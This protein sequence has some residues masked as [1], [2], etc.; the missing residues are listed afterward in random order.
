MK[1]KTD[2]IIS[3]NRIAF[4]FPMYISYTRN[5]DAG[6]QSYID[7]CNVQLLFFA[8]SSML[9]GR[10]DFLSR[11]ALEGRLLYRDLL[12]SFSLRDKL[13]IYWASGRIADGFVARK[14]ESRQRERQSMREGSLSPSY[15]IVGSPRRHCYEPI[16]NHKMTSRESY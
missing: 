6:I 9:R 11:G 16:R 2:T 12:A 15:V 14:K 8:R 4:T 10:R 1:N 13:R 7:D 5:M 3:L